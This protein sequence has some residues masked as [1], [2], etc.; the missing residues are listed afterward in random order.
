[1]IPGPARLV[2]SGNCRETGLPV[3]GAAVVFTMAA[4]FALTGPARSRK[5]SGFALQLG[6]SQDAIQPG[7]ATW[8]AGAPVF[9]IVTMMNDSK[10][11][12]HC[13][14]THPGL[15][16]G[17]DV[18]DASGNAVPPTEHFRQMKEALKSGFRMTARNILVTLE[19]HQT[20]QDTIEVSFLYD[21][22]RPGEYSIE[23]GREFHEVGKDPVRSN[24]LKLTITP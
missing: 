19:P 6:P 20:Q 8:K 10:R 1:M 18:R 2:L 7:E 12:V 11:T 21:L 15:D 17:M 22:S 9:V 24:R 5:D 16:Y 13:S 14:L 3:A 4:I 23:V